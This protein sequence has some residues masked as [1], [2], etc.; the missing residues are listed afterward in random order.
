MLVTLQFLRPES[1]DRIVGN[2]IDNG[3]L[4]LGIAYGILNLGV[5]VYH[6]Q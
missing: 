6:R 2:G 3:V 5:I 1:C 4:V